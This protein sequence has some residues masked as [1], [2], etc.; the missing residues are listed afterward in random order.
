MSQIANWRARLKSAW[1]FT[2][3]IVH[4]F[5]PFVEMKFLKH[6]RPSLAHPRANNTCHT[7][8]LKTPLNST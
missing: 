3:A 6:F 7:A 2:H 4:N 8:N 5:R 1:K